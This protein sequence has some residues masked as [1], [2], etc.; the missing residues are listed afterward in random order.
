M[1]PPIKP[2][3]A[4]VTGA[5]ARV[6]QAIAIELAKAGFEVAIHYRN[7]QNGALSTLKQCNGQGFIVQADL[8][9]NEGVESLI[10]QITEKWDTLD[11]L[12]N[13][14]S[15][16]EG[17]AFAEISMSQWDEMMQLHIKTPFD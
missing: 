8:N 3:R 5:G 13:N 15:I 14:A 4:L 6:G 7:S 9:T 12:V 10:S 1:N 2:K 16:F 17:V 11:L